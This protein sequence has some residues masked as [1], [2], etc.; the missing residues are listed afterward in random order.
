VNKGHFRYERTTLTD[1]AEA[2]ALIRREGEY[3]DATRPPGLIVMV[4]HLPKHGGMEV[5]EEIRGNAEFADLLV[6]VLSSSVL[7]EEKNRV[8]ALKQIC[9]IS[10]PLDLDGFM[11]FCRPQ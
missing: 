5:L 4:R 8:T 10:K 1:G 6:V 2:L 3:A 7:P 11:K 9:F